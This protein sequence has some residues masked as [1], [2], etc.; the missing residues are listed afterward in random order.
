MQN[1]SPGRR[2]AVSLLWLAVFLGCGGAAV[3]WL[4]RAH[5]SV[6]VLL[7]GAVLALTAVRGGVWLS[8]SRAVRRLNAVVEAYAERELAR[9]RRQGPR[10][11]V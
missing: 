4:G 1:Y 5:D 3:L 2:N 9:T 7:A 6:E 11:T 8:R 10:A